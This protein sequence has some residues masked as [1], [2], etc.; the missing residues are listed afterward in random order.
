MQ[1]ENQADDEM[2]GLWVSYEDTLFF[3]VT[4]LVLERS[5]TVKKKNLCIQIMDVCFV[6]RVL[7]VDVFVI[8]LL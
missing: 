8:D 2:F 4:T 6:T 7:V 5:P 1:M 3:Q